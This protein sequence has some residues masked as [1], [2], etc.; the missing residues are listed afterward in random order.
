MYGRGFVCYG[1]QYSIRWID[2]NSPLKGDIVG[3][4]MM[5]EEAA[6]ATIHTLDQMFE[7]GAAP[8]NT[9]VLLLVKRTSS[10][11]NGE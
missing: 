11:L 3:F 6:F 8:H 1:F 9:L 5:T 10:T 4:E 7:I 2:L